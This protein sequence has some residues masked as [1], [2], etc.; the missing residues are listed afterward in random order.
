[1]SNN[2]YGKGTPSRLPDKKNSTLQF[3]PEKGQ[4]PSLTTSQVMKKQYDQQQ[5]PKPQSKPQEQDKQQIEQ[6]LD[7]YKEKVF[8][9]LKKIN[10]IQQQELIKENQELKKKME[11]QDK[12]MQQIEQLIQQQN[13]KIQQQEL[14]KGNQEIQ[15]KMEQQDLKIQQQDYK[16]Q[17][18][19]EK[20]QQQEL[21]IE[22]PMENQGN[23]EIQEK[24]QNFISKNEI[25]HE[26]WR[27]TAEK[28]SNAYGIIEKQS[29]DL[30]IYKKQIAEKVNEYN[31]NMTQLV[32]DELQILEQQLNQTQQQTCQ[33]LEN[34]S[35]YEQILIKY[36]E[37][38]NK[39]LNIQG[40]QVPNYNNNQFQQFNQQQQQQQPQYSQQLDQQQY[41]QLQL[42]QYQYQQ[43]QQQYQQQLDQQQHSLPIHSQINFITPPQYQQS[44]PNYNQ[45]TQN[46]TNSQIQ[47]VPSYQDS[48]VKSKIRLLSSTQGPTIQ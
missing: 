9:E 45:N 27:T 28:I 11:Q 43:Q 26:I 35:R 32:K 1:M 17:Q 19:E 39:C 36:C 15:K 14:I 38:I 3:Q 13:E 22:S 18:L 40:I 2:T 5:V 42:D 29:Q 12:K 7:E 48:Q 34:L 10:Q 8:E 46:D 25:A 21:K 31:I 30:D 33:N 41:S 4:T 37:E 20:I 6:A 44:Q 23:T 24:I 47:F 16:I